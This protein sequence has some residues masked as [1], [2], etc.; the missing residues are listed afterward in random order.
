MN[1]NK[2]YTFTNGITIINTTPHSITFKDAGELISVPTS[3]ILINAKA[4]E[5]IV[6]NGTPINPGKFT[7][8]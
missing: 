6:K 5:T 2:T 8:F 1:N 4:I 3:G 7:T